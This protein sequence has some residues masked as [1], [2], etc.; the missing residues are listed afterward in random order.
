MI[1]I[2]ITIVTVVANMRIKVKLCCVFFYIKVKLI[3][4]SKMSI[5]KNE[6]IVFD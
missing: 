6:I 1:V 4:T 2:M 5:I 3:I